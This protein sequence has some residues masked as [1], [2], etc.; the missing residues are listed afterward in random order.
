MERSPRSGEVDDGRTVYRLFSS[1]DARARN[2]GA[3]P[4]PERAVHLAKPACDLPPR[5]ADHAPHHF[6]A[7]GRLSRTNS[8]PRSPVRRRR[9]CRPRNAVRARRRTCRRPASRRGARPPTNTS[10]P[11]ACRGQRE[12]D[13]RARRTGW[14]EEKGQRELVVGATP[15]STSVV[16]LGVAAALSLPAWSS[17]VTFVVH[18]RR[19]RG[20]VGPRDVGPWCRRRCRADRERRRRAAIPTEAEV[21]RRAR[22]PRERVVRSRDD[23]SAA[24]LR[25]AGR[26][27]VHGLCRSRAWTSTSTR[28]SQIA[29]ATYTD[30]FGPVAPESATVFTRTVYVPPW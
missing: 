13:R 14:S 7:A 3:R 21:L 4:E 30:Q 18:A 19:A 25:R 16:T 20:R 1:D 10:T 28:S 6:A 24:R 22:L 15:P 26:D 29:L 12:R 2:H 8:S 11:R 17:A 27:V 23:I 9:R 5:R